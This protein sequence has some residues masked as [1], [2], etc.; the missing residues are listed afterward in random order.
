[1]RSVYHLIMAVWFVK[2]SVQFL[3]VLIFWTR[4]GIGSSP[5]ESSG[6]HWTSVDFDWTG[7]GLGIVP[8]N[9]A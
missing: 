7:T 3:M 1:M 2:V 6:F 8:A 4:H 9:F 5:V